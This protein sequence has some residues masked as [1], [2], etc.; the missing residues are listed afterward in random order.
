MVLN[1]VIR[2]YDCTLFRFGFET[3]IC[4]I[5]LEGSGS[6][7]LSLMNSFFPTFMVPTNR[8]V[9]FFQF[10]GFFFFTALN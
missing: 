2:I 4:W 8:F 3:E 5:D 10:R 9:G 1:A 7:S 6:L